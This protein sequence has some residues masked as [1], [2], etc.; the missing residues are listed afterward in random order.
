MENKRKQE[1]FGI[2]FIIISICLMVSLFFYN[3]VLSPTISKAAE[4]SN[5]FGLLGIH[6]NFYAMKYVGIGIYFLLLVPLFSGI[7][8]LSNKK[9]DS[10]LNVVWNF[11]FLGVL[12][13][14]LM[15]LYFDEIF[16]IINLAENPAGVLGLTFSTFFRDNYLS[17]KGPWCFLTNSE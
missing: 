2:S 1:I 12:A 11:L 8:L 15:G 3:P 13:S 17:K 14:S 9:I 5:P 16:H 4:K 6:F 10:H 7:L